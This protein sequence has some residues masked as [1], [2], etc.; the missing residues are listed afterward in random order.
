M[1]TVIFEQ[2]LIISI[3]QSQQL[4]STNKT[5]LN[6]ALYGSGAYKYVRVPNFHET[7][8]LATSE[9]YYVCE[10]IMREAVR[11]AFKN[12]SVE[13]LPTQ[14]RKC[15]EFWWVGKRNFYFEWQWNQCYVAIMDEKRLGETFGS[16]KSCSAHKRFGQNRYTS[17]SAVVSCNMSDDF[18][19]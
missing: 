6:H 7:I 13:S 19:K 16:T 4:R 14:F 10:Y 15:L 2:I 1:N 11:Q 8:C 18:D 12:I 9:L 3:D 17:H 5:N